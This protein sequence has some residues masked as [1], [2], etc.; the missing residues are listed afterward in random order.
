LTAPSPNAKNCQPARHRTPGDIMSEH[1]ATSSRNARATSSE[2]AV[3]QL[4]QILKTAK[5]VTFKA[6]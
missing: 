5:G 1:R 6:G 4:D 2:S 3:E